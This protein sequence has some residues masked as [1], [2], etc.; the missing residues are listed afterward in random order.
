MGINSQDSRCRFLILAQLLKSEFFPTK[1]KMQD[2]LDQV[3]RKEISAKDAIEIMAASLTLENVSSVLELAFVLQKTATNKILLVASTL[4]MRKIAVYA[5]GNDSDLHLEIALRLKIVEL[6]FRLSPRQKQDK[7]R[8][9]ASIGIKK[10]FANIQSVSFAA[11]AR[12][13]LASFNSAS[14]GS[15]FAGI[16]AL[17]IQSSV[18]LSKNAQDVCQTCRFVD[19]DTT[20]LAFSTLQYPYSSI[21][22]FITS[23]KQVLIETMDSQI[24]IEMDKEAILTL[25]IVFDRN[26]I[27]MISIICRNGVN[28][29]QKFRL[30]KPGYVSVSSI[31]HRLTLRRYCL[32]ELSGN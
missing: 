11:D 22:Q 30:V 28:Q 15:C 29:V 4:F 9:A 20:Q 7:L 32:K 18:S 5:G 1:L 23:D 31:L 21:K 2:L 24:R 27:V 16:Q 3:Q 25:E 6:L 26:K 17:A 10:E 8:F 14:Q 19:F 13:F 12:V